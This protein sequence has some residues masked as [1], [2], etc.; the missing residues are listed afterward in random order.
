MLPGDPEVPRGGIERLVAQQHLDRPDVGPGFEQVRRA[1]RAER[2]D[3]WAGWNPRALL[4]M[5]GDLWG[6]ADGHRHVRIE[7]R[8]QP[9]GWPV[10]WP[11]GAQCGQQTGREQGGAILPPCALFD[12]EPPAITCDI[13]EP[14][15]DDFAN[16]QASGIR[17]HQEDAVP[18]ML[19]MREQA[20]ECRDAQDS[21]ELRPSRPWW[22]VAVEDIPP[23]GLR[24]EELPPC[25]RLMAGTPRPAPRDEEVVQR[26]THWLWAQAV[27]GTLGECGSAGPSGGLGHLCLRGQPLQR[28]IV[29]HLGT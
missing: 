29:D 28:H 12:A 6:R 13:R 14:Q 1:T 23:Q 8:Q 16:A 19:R 26:C 21:W 15:P 11:V 24:R 2:M 9:R 3:A 5:I 22:E 18:R 4:R 10:A 20:L 27:R 7:T 25:G 17:G